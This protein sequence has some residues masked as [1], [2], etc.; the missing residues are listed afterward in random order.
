[1]RIRVNKQNLVEVEKLVVLC[2][3]SE[4]FKTDDGRYSFTRSLLNPS[5]GTIFESYSGG[6]KRRIQVVKALIRTFGREISAVKSL[7]GQ[8][9]V[10]DASVSLTQH[11]F[12]VLMGGKE[13]ACLCNERRRT[14]PDFNQASPWMLY[15]MEE[16]RYVGARYV[17]SQQRDALPPG[18]WFDPVDAMR[19]VVFRN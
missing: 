6:Y 17:L 12:R 10:I 18:D 7:V 14:K 5:R 11:R 15:S 3:G 19:Q 9:E 2:T 8:V 16:A 1:M 13:L 4:V